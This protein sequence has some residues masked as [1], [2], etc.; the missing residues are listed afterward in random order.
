M[1]TQLTFDSWDNDSSDLSGNGNDVFLVKGAF[2]DE[3]RNVNNSGVVFDGI[4]DY[5]TI[6][7]EFNFDLRV[8]K[9]GRISYGHKN[10]SSAPSS[11][12]IQPGL[13]YS[14]VVVVDS[15]TA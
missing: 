11:I 5:A 14:L 13:Y 9:D 1:E 10:W 12:S 3:G 7:N 4:D 6:A 2:I 15:S 8:L